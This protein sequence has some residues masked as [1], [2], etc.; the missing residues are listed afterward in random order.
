MWF[1][2]HVAFRGPGAT[3]RYELPIFGV[4]SQRFKISIEILNR[5]STKLYFTQFIIFLKKNFNSK[6]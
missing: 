5:L 4:M 1:V 6:K 2:L 3:Q